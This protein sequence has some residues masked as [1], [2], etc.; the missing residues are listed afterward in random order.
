MRKT[1]Q[2]VFGAVFMA[3]GAMMLILVLRDSGPGDAGQATI[4]PLA[5]MGAGALAISGARRKPKKW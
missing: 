2:I 5:L 3:V 4:G 1:L